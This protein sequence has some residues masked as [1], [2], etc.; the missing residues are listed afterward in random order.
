M[1]CN[2]EQAR[3]RRE[4][5][6][7]RMSALDMMET[8]RGRIH[9]HRKEENVGKRIKPQSEIIT[10]VDQA[11]EALA[12]LAGIE[13]RLNAITAT[14]N[15]SIDKLK[16]NADA[17][18]AKHNERKKALATALNGFAEVNRTELFARKKSLELPHGVIGWRQSTSIVAKAKVKMA[19]VLEK[20]KDLGWNDAVKTSESVNKEAMREWSDGKLEAVGMERKIADQFFVEISAEALKG[21]A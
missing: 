16:S 13:R 1:L 20:L 19:Q 11:K 15:E 12:E 3:I 4:A 5:R 8:G 9:K 17:E 6:R 10:T 2:R 18:A 21:E 7:V 14:M